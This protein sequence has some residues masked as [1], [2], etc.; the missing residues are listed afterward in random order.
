MSDAIHGYAV[1]HWCC[2]TCVHR[3]GGVERLAFS[4]LWE[5]THN[6]DVVSVRFTKSVISSRAA[7]TYAEA[8]TR[9]D[10]ESMN[11]DIT[12]GAHRTTLQ[13]RTLCVYAATTETP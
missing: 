6:A 5:M 1:T 11:D 4:A 10:D 12:V 3:R 2:G 7:L 13:R 9:I 8:Q